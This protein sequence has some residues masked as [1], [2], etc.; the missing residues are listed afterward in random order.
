MLWHVAGV[1]SFLL[2]STSPLV[3]ITQHVIHS[4]VDRHLGGFQFVALMTR[5]L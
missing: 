4:L 1:H 2:L 3:G 5:L